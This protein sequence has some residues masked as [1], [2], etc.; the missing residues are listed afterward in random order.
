MYG[1]DCVHHSCVEPIKGVGVVF[2]GH[3]VVVVSDVLRRRVHVKAF[4]WTIDGCYWL[5]K[6]L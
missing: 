6:G 1:S 5:L 4:M 3:S 2:Y